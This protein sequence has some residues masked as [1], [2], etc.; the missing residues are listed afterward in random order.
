VELAHKVCLITGASGAIGSAVAQR[1]CEEDAYVV[2]TYLSNPSSIRRPGIG[3]DRN[4]EFELDVCNYEQIQIVLRK[5]VDKFGRIDALVNCAGVIGPIG[6]T[7]DIAVDDWV[8]AIEVNLIGSFC[9]TRGVL[10]FMLAQSR[11]KIIHFSGGGAAYAR[12]FCTAYAASK[13]ALVRFVESLAAELQQ[14]HIEV[15][16]IA[17]GPVYSR[18][19]EQMR[20]AG[21]KGG[22]NNLQELKKMEETGGVPPDRAANLA[23]F[24][25]SDRSNGLSGRLISAVHD[26]W[27]SL[28]ARIA[29]VMN[30]ESGTLRRV[31]F[32]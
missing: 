7:Q 29:D 18:M 26:D 10:P 20:A 16:A 1:F 12:P 11:G 13:A 32:D 2:T 8:R 27:A 17:P 4:L 9:L 30:S 3:D 19:W 6:S 5:V 14:S 23:V 24:L 15:N 22:D 28:E 25:A 31:P 21:Q